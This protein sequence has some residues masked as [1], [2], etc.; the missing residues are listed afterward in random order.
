MPL[1]HMG[2][3]RRPVLMMG[4]ANC[5][6]VQGQW[7][8]VFIAK[9]HRQLPPPPSPVAVVGL[10]VEGE[11]DFRGL[12]V[13]HHTPAAWLDPWIWLL[14]CLGPTLSSWERRVGDGSGCL[15][16]SPEV[17]GGA[18]YSSRPQQGAKTD[19]ATDVPP[20][21]RVASSGTLLPF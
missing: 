9:K 3:G 2:S 7:H 17:P 10:S 14:A 6:L 12:G 13:G 20:W 21:C 15:Y 8:T 1:W 19:L 4:R 11:G 5:S 18:N 16:P